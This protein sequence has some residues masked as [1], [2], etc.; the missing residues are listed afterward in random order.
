MLDTT[1]EHGSYH[2]FMLIP[3]CKVGDHFHMSRDWPVI[4]GY[5]N[6]CH[7]LKRRN[8]KQKWVY[9]KNI[10]DLQDP[11]I[12]TGTQAIIDQ[13]KWE[14]NYNYGLYIDYLSINLMVE[15][16]DHLL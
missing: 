3:P 5:V 6:V 2:A 7:E 11:T 16:M 10:I 9:P 4:N 14:P 1:I 13:Q 8:Q 12:L 15:M